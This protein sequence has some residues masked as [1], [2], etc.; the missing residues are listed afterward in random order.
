[1]D[2]A[3]PI[4]ST[5]P[6]RSFEFFGTPR[7]QLEN[8]LK[9]QFGVPAY[10]AAQLYQW[11]YQHG[12]ANIDEMTS[13][14]RELRE[15]LRSSLEVSP[16]PILSEQVSRDGTRKYLVETSV[17]P[18]ETVLIHQPGRKTLCV[19]SQVGCGMGCTFCR[20]ATMGFQKHLKTSDIVRQVVT[21]RRSARERGEDFS[22]IVFMGMGEPLH[23]IR[24]VAPAVE[25]LTDQ[26]GLSFAPR[27]ITIS[28]VG[29][30]PII[31]R[32]ASLTSANLAVSLNATTDEVRSS[33][34]P[35]TKRYPLSDLTKAL[36]ELSHQI[37]RKRITIE[38]VL[39]AGIND[40]DADLTR[41]PLVLEGIRSKINLIPY[42]ENAGLGFYAPRKATID[43]WYQTLT[44]KGHL[45]TV[46]WSKGDDINA[47][48]GQLK[49]AYE[50][51]RK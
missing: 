17:G 13:L 26:H 23:N 36:R 46:R 29:L 50:S 41:L 33:I 20:T 32:F 24:A 47:A 8:T 44:A 38:Y 5:L 45:V 35:I 6:Q 28:T 34:M 22:N 9:T 19:S 12:V 48:C 14:S 3:V 40:T 43:K 25:I 7:S 31:R 49:T 18:V 11:I 1:M 37:G 51:S 42:N 21:V 4:E 2:I 15:E 39:L 16:A 10:R 27:R 30:V